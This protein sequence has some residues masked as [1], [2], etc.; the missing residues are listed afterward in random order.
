MLCSRAV[1]SKR[2]KMRKGEHK[3]PIESTWK[4]AKKRGSVLKEKDVNN[5]KKLQTPQKELPE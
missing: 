4:T 5:E 1:N 2:T 3:K